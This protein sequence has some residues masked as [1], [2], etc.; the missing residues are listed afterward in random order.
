MAPLL[1][2]LKMIV[3]K[4]LRILTYR[5]CRWKPLGATARYLHNVAATSIGQ[6]LKSLSETTS[7]YLTGGSVHRVVPAL[8][9]IDLMVVTEIT[10]DSIL[11]L[12]R[13]ARSLKAL[14]WMLGE[15]LVLDQ[16]TLK[17]L[18]GSGSALSI[19]LFGDKKLLAG[20]DVQLLPAT[21]SDPKSLFMLMMRFYAK[22]TDVA[23]SGSRMSSYDDADCKR[24]LSKI[25]ALNNG[26]RVT[27]YRLIDDGASLE[28]Y[29]VDAYSVLDQ[30]AS[31]LLTDL[32]PDGVPAVVNQ[33]AIQSAETTSQNNPLR[34]SESAKICR[35]MGLT[36]ESL[37]PTLNR[38][39][40]IPEDIS[41]LVL[42]H[43]IRE[44]ALRRYFQLPGDMTLNSREAIR[45][46]LN[47]FCRLGC[48]LAT[49][50]Y[51]VDRSVL[52]NKSREHLPVTALIMEKTHQDSP[53]LS[54]ETLIEAT[55]N[56]RHELEKILIHP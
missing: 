35:F 4:P 51:F 5:A 42:K 52:A 14:Y 50:Q 38:L 41:T 44:R 23:A 22:A 33:I 12:R 25:V 20:T 8:S 24:Y 49:N 31:R 17:H 47:Q 18:Q 19:H 43:S 46:K 16:K 32:F 36:L 48:Y 54:L 55:L 6:S 3:P 10:T 9:D 45:S 39:T 28:S 27:G 37:T 2:G 11:T 7:V 1:K 15:I 13:R 34:L 21:P 30:R 29:F 26:T 53:E 56:V 40:S